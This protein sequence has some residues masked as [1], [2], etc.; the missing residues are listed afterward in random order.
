MISNVLNVFRVG[1][2]V[3]H[4]YRLLLLPLFSFLLFLYDLLASADSLLVLLESSFDFNLAAFVLLRNW[5]GARLEQ[6]DGLA[7]VFCAET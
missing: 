6:V 3:G 5:L 1:D 7:F 2:D 4:L